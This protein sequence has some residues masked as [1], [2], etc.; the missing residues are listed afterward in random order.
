MPK[1]RLSSLIRLLGGYLSLARDTLFRLRWLPRN[2][3]PG[4]AAARAFAA[5]SGVVGSGGG[6]GDDGCGYDDAGESG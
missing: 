4:V 2:A 5:T 3:F 6:G 1:F